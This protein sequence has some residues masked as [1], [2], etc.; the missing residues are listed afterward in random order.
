MNPLVNTTARK[1][2]AIMEIALASIGL[3]PNSFSSSEMIGD[4]NQS[5]MSIKGIKYDVC[6]SVGQEHKFDFKAIQPECCL[7]DRMHIKMR[8]RMAS[9]IE[10]AGIMKAAEAIRK[11]E[12]MK[13]LQKKAEEDKLKKEL[14]AFKTE[15]DKHRELYDPSVTVSYYDDS[16]RAIN[17][18]VKVETV[19]RFARK[20]SPEDLER[21]DVMD[22]D[23][24]RAKYEQALLDIFGPDG[25]FVLEIQGS[26][27]LFTI[28]G[29]YFS[30]LI[31]SYEE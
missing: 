3:D 23:F 24:D 8:A 30:F 2:L 22:C 17:E 10:A 7:Y 15:E 14:D 28:S 19:L 4:E 6:V 1:E 20:I 18:T 29:T 11:D 31:S 25:I 5:D 12:A 26:L 16:N 27:F 9:S 13:R 21:A